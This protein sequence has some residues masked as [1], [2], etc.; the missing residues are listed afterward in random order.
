[1]P[2]PPPGSQIHRNGLPSK[3]RI[4]RDSQKSG[5]WALATRKW[6]PHHAFELLV[7]SHHFLFSLF[8]AFG[9]LYRLFIG[10]IYSSSH[11]HYHQRPTSSSTWIR[12]LPEPPL[13]AKDLHIDWSLACQ[14]EHKFSVHFGESMKEVLRA[15][16][17]GGGPGGWCGWRCRRRRWA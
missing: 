16:R 11:H 15:P 10:V 6:L 13:R 12:H 14:K 17:W 4:R 5:R 1:M 3:G 2:L 8:F 7:I 9:F